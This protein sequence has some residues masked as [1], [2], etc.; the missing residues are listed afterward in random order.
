MPSCGM[1]E[2]D[3]I[4]LMYKLTVEDKMTTIKIADHLNALGL[5]PSYFID[6]PATGR[7]KKETAGI[8]RPGRVLN[9][10]KSTTYKGVHQYGKRST[11]QREIIER[12]VPAIVSPEDWE[13]AQ[14][15]ICSHYIF[16][17]RNAKH[18]YLLTSL[19]K[20]KN[21]GYTYQS[22]SSKGSSYYMCGGR[23]YWRVKGREKCYGRSI[24]MPWLDNYI[25]NDCLKYINNPD[26][27][28]EEIEK[29]NTTK[30]KP[31]TITDEKLLLD[32]QLDQKESEKSRILDLFR[33]QLISLNDVE[34]QLNKISQEKAII[35]E[36]VS[37]INEK[38]KTVSNVFATQASAKKLLNHLKD[39]I[40][41]TENTVE[42]KREI[43]MSIVDKI[44]V[45]TIDESKKANMN[46]TNLTK[47]RKNRSYLPK[48][49]TTRTRIHCRNEH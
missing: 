21:C 31:E 33:R 12:T 15:I 26:T 45:A 32:T 40:S 28:I 48:L 1:S 16:S 44:T 47:T 41:S 49:L 22:I 46:I 13:E 39:K 30:S 10:L 9:M 23:S 25:W 19:I 37:T 20:C 43:I 35:Q 5:P 17:R 24:N 2:A 42:F 11:R 8:W 18:I 7:R 27:A 36:R 3:I 14:K 29:N 38:E 34:L 4:R 6:S